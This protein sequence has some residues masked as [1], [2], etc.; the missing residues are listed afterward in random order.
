MKRVWKR[1][2]IA[3]AVLLALD[4]GLKLFGPDIKYPSGR[5]T[6]NSYGDG[7][8]QTLKSYLGTE[9]LV[10]WQYNDEVIDTITAM[11]ANDETAYFYGFTNCSAYIDGPRDCYW[12]YAKLKIE[13]N[14]LWV[15]FEPSEA[16][17][18]MPQGDGV[19]ERLARYKYK[20]LKDNPLME[21]YAQYTDF[22][23]QD[24]AIFDRLRENGQQKS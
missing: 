14:Q 8:Y 1:I 24:R 19:P 7:T 22:S 12:I 3:G 15:Y 20:E 4:L 5:D 6:T 13:T 2:I 11:D 10:N 23:E 17:E 9:S 21:V 18:S 16:C